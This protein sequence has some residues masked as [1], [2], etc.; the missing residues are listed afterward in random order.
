MPF[1]GIKIE[2][3]T[4]IREFASYTF[5]CFDRDKKKKLSKAEI[6]R[7]LHASPEVAASLKLPQ[8]GSFFEFNKLFDAMDLDED[9]IL[10]C[11][12]MKYVI[13]MCIRFCF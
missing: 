2:S 4:N 9:G 10:F 11:T 6:V 13:I 1:L 12:L 3:F 7:A 5:N 8:E